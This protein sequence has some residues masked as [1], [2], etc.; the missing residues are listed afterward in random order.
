MVIMGQLK[1]TAEILM[2]GTGCNYV[3]EKAWI[4]VIQAACDANNINTP[5]RVA[6]FLANI[7]VESGSLT[8]LKECLNYSAAGL[9]GTWPNRFDKNPSDN[10]NEPN[11]LA[12]SIANKPERI[13]N[14]VYGGRF[15]NGNEASGDGLKYIGRG[16][17]QTT[18]KANYVAMQALTGC[19]I[20]AN[21]ALL[22]TKLVAASVAA[23]Q[24][25]SVARNAADRGDIAGCVKLINGA[26]PNVANQ[27]A[28]RIKR[29]NDCMKLFG[30]GSH[31]EQGTPPD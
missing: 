30:V 25:M 20:V 12:I 5:R 28:L 3:N 4:D 21:P 2:A 27:G 13:A 7:G 14:I 24:F 16:L 8:S 22:E 17:L 19:Q 23:A 9:A 18:F 26:P 29:F 10:K 15:G 1:L 6:A 11:A 31:Q